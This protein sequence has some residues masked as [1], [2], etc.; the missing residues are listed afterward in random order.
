MRFVIVGRVVVI[1]RMRMFVTTLMR[2]RM[3]VVVRM[4]VGMFVYMRMA[5]HSALGLQRVGDVLAQVFQRLGKKIICLKNQSYRL[6]NFLCGCGHSVFG[7]TGGDLFIS[8]KML[9]IVV[10]PMG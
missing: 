5:V 1:M 10:Q 6:L 8:F 2:M 4:F 3:L 7:Q 9:D